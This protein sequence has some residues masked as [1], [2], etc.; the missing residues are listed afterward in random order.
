[1]S[2]GEPSGYFLH[3]A[4]QFVPRPVA[5]SA[6]AADAV[7]GRLLGGLGVHVLA[8]ER[9]E[10]DLVTARVTVDLFRT[11]AY[12][13][14]AVTT[15]VL[16]KGRR[17]RVADAELTQRGELVARVTA[18]QLLSSEDPAGERWSGR[19]WRRQPP[20]GLSAGE[21]VI[22]IRRF[23]LDDDQHDDQH[24]DLDIDH[25]RDRRGWGSVARHGSWVCERIPLV[26]GEALT[27]LVRVAIAADATSPMTNTGPAGL[28]FINTD[29]TLLLSRPPVGDTFGL[30]TLDHHSVEGISIGQASVYDAAGYLGTAAV[31]AIANPG[32][33]RPRHARRPPSSG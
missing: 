2:A 16:R 13:P 15:T 20:P 7:N 30:E 5:A 12:A 27:P 3:D 29:F 14:I 24:D 19:R 23:T 25:G 4:D 17:I 8:G 11:V 18:V 22:G 21:S 10:P 31:T 9:L 33:L 32:A 26:A 1:V 6:W 28:D